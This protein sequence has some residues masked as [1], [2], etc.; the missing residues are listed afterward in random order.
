VHYS[1]LFH[2][3]ESFD[4][5]ITRK[6]RFLSASTAGFF[7]F[8]AKVSRVGTTYWLSASIAGLLYMHFHPNTDLPHKL[9]GAL[10]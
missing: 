6:P 8:P 2:A 5:L 9:T 3:I 1:A 10:I 4:D 7:Y